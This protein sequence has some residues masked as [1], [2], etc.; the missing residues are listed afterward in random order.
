MPLR[1]FI[2]WHLECKITIAL[3][4]ISSSGMFMWQLED[5]TVSTALFIRCISESS[6]LL[7]AAFAVKDLKSYGHMDYLRSIHGLPVVSSEPVLVG[8]EK[9]AYIPK[10][11]QI[12]TLWRYDLTKKGNLTQRPTSSNHCGGIAAWLPHTYFLFGRVKQ[13]AVLSSHRFTLRYTCFMKHMFKPRA[14]NMKTSIC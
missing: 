9:T 14:E 11:P 10:D 7:F 5:H 4:L 3:N 8:Q 1:N 6:H 13:A 12:R 2:T